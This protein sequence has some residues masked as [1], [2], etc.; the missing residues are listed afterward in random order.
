MDISKQILWT[1]SQ[2]VLH[3]L[4]TKKP[5]AVFI[6]NRIKEILMEKDISFRYIVSDQ[7]PAQSTLWWH[8]PSWLRNDESSWP[9]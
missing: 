6:E 1:N 7:N 5:L 4:K 8:G 3:W 9:E 2:C